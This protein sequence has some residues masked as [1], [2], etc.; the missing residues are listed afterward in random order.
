MKR[1][2]FLV[3]AFAVA[4]AIPLSAQQLSA[5]VKEFSGKVEVK[6]PG[7]DWTP[8]TADMVLTNGT[9]VSTGFGA[10]LV[11]Q[12]GLTRVTVAP[13]TRLLLEDIVKRNTT[14][15]ASL[16]LAV[17]KVSAQVK[18]AEGETSQFTLKGPASTAAVRGTEFSFDGYTLN[19]TEGVVQFFNLL[20]QARPVGA[21]ES[22][23][24]DGFSF[25]DSGEHHHQHDTD[26]GGASTG[27]LAGQGGGGGGSGSGGQFLTG[28]IVV[29]AE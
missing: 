16:V 4:F 3:A 23:T 19:V 1:A 7:A 5:V 17:G 8:V 15:A 9:T 27:G 11:L 25:P 20:A 12:I 13:V 26:V 22:S 6:A 14:N 10:R 24:T 2:L 21:G 18:S 28:T 29:T